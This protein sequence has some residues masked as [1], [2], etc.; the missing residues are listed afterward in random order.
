MNEDKI[1]PVPLSL[2]YSGLHSSNKQ[3]NLIKLYFSRAFGS[4][5][6]PPLRRYSSLK[7]FTVSRDATVLFLN[8]ERLFSA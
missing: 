2:F 7:N 8:I 1:A 3:K 6:V 4:R 5:I